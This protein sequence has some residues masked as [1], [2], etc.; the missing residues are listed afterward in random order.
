MTADLEKKESELSVLHTAF[1]CLQYGEYKLSDSLALL[2]YP[3][4]TKYH[5]KY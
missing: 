2:N 3:K 1:F 4:G 5:N